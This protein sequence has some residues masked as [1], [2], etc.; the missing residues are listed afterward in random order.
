MS[1]KIRLQDQIL[2]PP[3]PPLPILPQALPSLPFPSPRPHSPSPLSIISANGSE[4]EY[5][6]LELQLHFLEWDVPSPYP[7]TPMQQNSNGKLVPRPDAPVFNLLLTAVRVPYLA[8]LELSPRSSGRGTTQIWVRVLDIVD[9]TAE[10]ALCTEE[11]R[12]DVILRLN[13]CA[14]MHA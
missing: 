1:L 14:H 7:V 8:G 10:K 9:Y 5:Y 11:E 2:I 13:V 4:V 6:C 3:S 12:R